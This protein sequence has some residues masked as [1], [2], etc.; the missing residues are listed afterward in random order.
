MKDITTVM[1]VTHQLRIIRYTKIL[2]AGN[3]EIAT[4]EKWLFASK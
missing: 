4:Q 1:S 3:A 2:N